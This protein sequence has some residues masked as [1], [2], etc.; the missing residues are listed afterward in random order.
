M[1]TSMA[2]RNL[3]PEPADGRPQPLAVGLS[4]AGL[5]VLGVSAWLGGDLVYRMGWRVNKAEEAEQLEDTLR[6][7]GQTDLVNQAQQTVQQYEQ[8]R[9]ILP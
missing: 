2:V 4:T 8:E 1:L 9:A 5:A 7:R 6:K 3:A